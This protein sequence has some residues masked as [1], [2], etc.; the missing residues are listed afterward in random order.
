VPGEARVLVRTAHGAM[1]GGLA[2]HPGTAGAGSGARPVRG[3]RATTVLRAARGVRTAAAVPNPAR[4]ARHGR[5]S[6]VEESDRAGG[7]DLDDP[8]AG[9][10]TAAATDPDPVRRPDRDR[11]LAR[12]RDPGHPPAVP[13]VGATAHDPVRTGRPSVRARDHRGCRGHGRDRAGVGQAGVGQGGVGLAGVGRSVVDRG[14]PGRPGRHDRRGRPGARYQSR[15]ARVRGTRGCRAPVGGGRAPLDRRARHRAG[16]VCH[17]CR[18]CPSGGVG[19][20][21]P[22]STVRRQRCPS[23]VSSTVTP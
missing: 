16:R 22:A 1:D 7:R 20:P 10:H 11:S 3:R 8:V 9:P 6:T 4:A 2:W 18:P 5:M 23:R 21:R 14:G 19:Q 15:Q 17:P 13:T 12:A